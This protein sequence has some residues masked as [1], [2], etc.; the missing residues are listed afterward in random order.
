MSGRTVYA[1]LSHTKTVGGGTFTATSAMA[2]AG[3][4]T[5]P[6]AGGTPYAR[7]AIVLGAISSTGVIS[8]PSTTWNPGNATDWPSDVAAWGIASASSSG[9]CIFFWDLAATRDMSKA[10]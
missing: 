2:T 3:E 10:N 9:T 7:Q 8:V 6:G 1:F 5:G 4:I